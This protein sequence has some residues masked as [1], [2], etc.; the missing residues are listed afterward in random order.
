MMYS[1]ASMNRFLAPACLVAALVG[2]SAL[3]AEPRISTMTPHG[4]KRGDTVEV[5]FTGTR[6]NDMQEVLFYEPGIT[7]EKLEQAKDAKGRPVDNVV[8]ATLK[9]APDTF[10]GEH[11]LR[12]RTKNG[13]T[14]SQNF[15][16]G[17]LPTVL[18]TEM[19]TPK[20]RNDTIETAQK[21]NLGVT[22]EGNIT[23]EDVDYYAVELKKGQRLTVE[24]EGI[25]LGTAMF[26]PSIAVLD[27]SKFEVARSDD[28]ALLK[29]D[30]T[31]TYVAE[32]DGTYF[33]KI[34][35]GEYGGGANYYYRMHV[36]DLPRPTAV[37][38]AGGQV[39]ESLRVTY[40]GDDKG[41]IEATIKLPDTPGETIAAV[42][43]LNGVLAPS[44]NWVRVSPFPNVLEAEP[45]DNF[46][47]VK[48]AAAPAPVAFNGIIEK[49]GDV[50]FFKFS[51]KKGQQF[52]INALARTLRTPL[53]PTITIHDSQGR[54]IAS[55]DDS[56]GE[57]DSY[58]R[59][60]VPADGEYYVSIKDQL[61]RG[62]RDFVY[63]IE[64]AEITPSLRFTIPEVARRETQN[65][66]WIA[67]PRGGRATV[68]FQVKRKDFSGDVKIS[69]KDLPAGVKMIAPDI[70][71]NAS[72]VALV[73]EADKDAPIAGKLCDI[74]GVSADGKVTGRFI[75]Q[76]DLV[77]GIPNNQ[78]YYDIPLP[79]LGVTVIEESPFAISLHQPKVPM[80]QSG[81]LNLKIHVDRKEGYTGEINGYLVSMP[82]GISSRSRFTI[83]K[84]QTD[85]ELPMTSSKSAAV[86]HWPLA[87]EAY[88]SAP[89]GGDI[90]VST[91]HI[92]LD[93][94]PAFVDGKIQLGTVEAGKSTKVT[95]DLQQKNAFEGKAKLELLGL[96]AAATAEPVMITKDDTSATVEVKTASNTP[97]GQHRSLVV[98]LTI[99]QNGEQI[100]QTFGLGGVIRVDR[101]GGAPA[102]VAKPAKK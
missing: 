34:Y 14:Y 66:Q 80:P 1:I 67:V 8:L 62:G 37:Y 91:S 43:E 46:K 30:P 39:G 19:T 56:G 59:F 20:E 100:V 7:V 47:D 4:G 72:E 89:S 77:R 18:E 95:I 94:V 75:Q 68:R 32:N 33:I 51:A 31:L 25:R 57:L 42:A 3:A 70:A 36:G 52:D 24:V 71:E 17:T 22:V 13:W 96:P 41:P 90:Y 10:I 23:N 60:R 11:H 2:S 50:D 58:I 73:F 28:S 69:C 86:G 102:P 82:N 45:N 44:P 61:N 65:R 35:D 15:Y 40:L 16:V 54:P 49:P 5:R 88:G 48:A 12:C 99:E 76:C 27:K 38:P 83:P 74:A 84:D 21:L 6:I 53:D 64:I 97:V 29:Q 98:Q 9:I 92:N 26:D 63:R 87:I 79:R 85:A 78:S 101:P 93:L 81:Q 55:N